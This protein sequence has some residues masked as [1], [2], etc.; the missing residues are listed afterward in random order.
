M[1]G[2]LSGGLRNARA[3]VLMLALLSALSGS[4]K[5]AGPPRPLSHAGRWITDASGRVVIL[6][7]TSMV[8][9][10][11]P[12][13]P[14]AAGFG[15]DDAAFL[16]SIGFNAVRVGVIWKALEPEPGVYDDSY[17]GQI[18]ATVKLLAAQ[19]I[20]SLLDFHQDLFNERF[21]GEG[22]PD[23]AVQDGGLPAQ[24]Q[25]G[26]PANYYSMPAL[27]RALEN[28]WANSPGPGGVGLQDRFAEAWRHVAQ[29]FA[30]NP[31]VLGYEIFNEPFPGKG[32]LPCYS[33]S[34]CPEFDAQLTAFYRKVDAAIR[35][36]DPRTLVWYEPNVLFNFG[37]VTHVA[38]I[39]DPRTGFAFHAY[40]LENEQRGCASHATTIENAEQYA[41]STG[42]A[43]AM[44]E[45]GA[46]DSVL[47]LHEV[48]A[49]ADQHMVPWFEWMYCGCSDPTTAA[50]PRAQAM[51]YDPSKPPTGAN[52][53]RKTV[54]AL[55]EPYPQAIAGTPRSWSFD[56]T[57]RTFELQY[58]TRAASG[59]RSFPVGS[60]TEIATPALKYP[61][62]Y[63][64]RVN[65]GAVVSAPDAAVLRIAS[66]RRSGSVSVKV[67]STLSSSQS[68]RAHLRIR[69]H[70]RT[71]RLDRLTAYRFT[72]KATLGSY[73]C[74]IAGA[75][76]SFGGRKA[77][78][79]K[80]GVAVFR[81]S[82]H[83]RPRPYTAF[84]SAAG[85]AS[86]RVRIGPP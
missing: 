46:T 72:V 9:K 11:P 83:R 31:A 18:A 81:L 65:G 34:G 14:G 40:C 29:R 68:C 62:G 5:A 10:V 67:A 66:C 16:K 8:Y 20:A 32:F 12:Y 76:L 30:G 44:T 55:A 41:V 71:L 47:D 36:A 59:R 2:A 58:A 51:V 63:H 57:S 42:D 39:G 1:K 17:L 84:A 78:T 26:F 19:G 23:W 7:G 21:Q 79:D 60:L 77:R 27:Q 25:L 64:V 22:A 54:G 13:Y 73:S 37:A 74:P 80:R 56:R 50:A 24:P 33:A 15:A 53:A 86:A 35:S 69:V 85:Y 28:F 49:L 70:P 3:G 48:V 75:K 45:F 6:H 38:P 52:V 43:L 61:S 4:A 82:L